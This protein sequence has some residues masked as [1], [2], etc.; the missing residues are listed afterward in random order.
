MRVMAASRFHC[1]NDIWKR[2]AAGAKL[3]SRRED[4]A[5]ILN[6]VKNHSAL[7]FRSAPVAKHEILS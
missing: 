3:L 7:L 2:K 6:E 5:V 1:P 4:L